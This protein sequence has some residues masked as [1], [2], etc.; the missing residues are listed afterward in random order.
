MKANEWLM[1]CDELNKIMQ[2]NQDYGLLRYQTYIPVLFY[3]L[4]SSSAQAQ[5]KKFKYPNSQYEVNLISLVFFRST[6][7][8]KLLIKI[9]LNR[10]F[11]F[12]DVCLI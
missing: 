9:F 6:S 8:V 5:N 4:F 11:L 12:R 10:E 7:S 1:T 3:T 2:H